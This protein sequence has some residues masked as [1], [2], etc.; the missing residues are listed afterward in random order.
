MEFGG[1]VALCLFKF[2]KFKF[3][4]YPLF[5]CKPVLTRLYLGVKWE[6]FFTGVWPTRRG[7]ITCGHPRSS[8]KRIL[9]STPWS[10]AVSQTLTMNY[11][12][13]S[14]TLTLV[15]SNLGACQQFKQ[16][17]LLDPRCCWMPSARPYLLDLVPK[18]PWGFIC[19]IVHVPCL[20]IYLHPKGQSQV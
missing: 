13:P 11:E 15:S 3:P 4:V 6:P 2:W 17:M 14:L 9:A 1:V 20:L 19:L 7:G 5:K 12:M 16:Q 10:W 18:Q 8:L